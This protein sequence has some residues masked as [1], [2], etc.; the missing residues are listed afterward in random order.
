MVQHGE[1]RGP[2]E[3][4][5]GI[6]QRGAVAMHDLDVVGVAKRSVSIEASCS[7]ISTEVMWPTFSQSTSV[8]AP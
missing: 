8:V 1:A 3:P 5:G 6:G 2:G 4:I 7:S